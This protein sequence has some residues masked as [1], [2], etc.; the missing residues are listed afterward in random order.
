MS[1]ARINDLM[2]RDYG[3]EFLCAFE[4]EEF[5]ESGGDVRIYDGKGQRF[6]VE[7]DPDRN[8]V[9]YGFIR[10]LSVDAADRPA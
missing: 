5:P 1:N 9:V 7:V 3:A 6:I 2:L 10:N 8:A 4:D